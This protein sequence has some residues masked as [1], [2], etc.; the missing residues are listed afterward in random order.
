MQGKAGLRIQPQCVKITEGVK[1]SGTL[2][3]P[4]F[5]EIGLSV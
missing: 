4:A 5:F 2:E 3:R 1:S